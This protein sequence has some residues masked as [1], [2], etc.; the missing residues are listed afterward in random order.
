MVVIQLQQGIVIVHDW[1]F[2]EITSTI[3]VSN[4]TLL[5]FFNSFYETASKHWRECL[6]YVFCFSFLFEQNISG[7]S[8][9]V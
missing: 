8:F 4:V 2:L 9:A 3:L 1:S 5:S 7:C 6:E